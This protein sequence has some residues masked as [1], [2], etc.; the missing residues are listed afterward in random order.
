M[1]T[2]SEISFAVQDQ[3]EKRVR[4]QWNTSDTSANPQQVN[5]GANTNYGD[6]QS[7]VRI[8][9]DTFEAVFVATS[10]PVHFQVQSGAATSADMEIDFEDA[11]PTGGTTTESAIINGSKIQTDTG[12]NIAG[13]STYSRFDPYDPSSPAVSQTYEPDLLSIASDK[14]LPDKTSSVT[15]GNKVLPGTDVTMRQ[16]LLVDPLTIPNAGSRFMR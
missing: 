10:D 9:Q 5:F 16:D 7:G 13:I 1:P 11:G 2:I 14:P 6:L 12:T 15:Q 3:A 4:V 8:G